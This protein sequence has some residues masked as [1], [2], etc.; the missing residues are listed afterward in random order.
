MK[1]VAIFP[2][3]FDPFTRGHQAIVEQA[4]HLFDKVVVAI[5]YNPEKRGLLSIEAR[6]RLI[7]AIYCNESRVEVTAYTTLTGEEAQRVGAK[8]IVRSVRNIIDF[9]YERNLSQANSHLYPDMQ[10][11]ILFA[12]QDVEHISS[13]LV[14]EL[15]TFNRNTDEFMPEG[16][17]LNDY[18]D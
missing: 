3:S 14:R 9:E 15:H 13:S 1:S 11:V 17:T 16:I 5:G 7:K 6:K 4:L 8:V 18:L 10:T 2:G 12:P